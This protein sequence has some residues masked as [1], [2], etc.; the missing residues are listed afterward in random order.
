VIDI[1]VNSVPNLTRDER[2]VRFTTETFDPLGYH[3]FFCISLP[4][5]AFFC[6]FV[7]T[8]RFVMSD[9][10]VRSGAAADPQQRRALPS[11]ER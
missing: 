5:S 4:F 6:C 9:I 2:A 11:G 10:S 3:F 7:A 1:C 8:F